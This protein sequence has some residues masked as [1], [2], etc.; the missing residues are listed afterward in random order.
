MRLAFWKKEDPK[1]RK[2]K[3]VAREWVD[4][5]IFAIVAATIIRTFLVEAYTIPTASMEGSMLTGDYLF[6][7]KVAYGPRIPNTPLA[8]P[9]VHNTMPI[10]GGKSY[11]EAV[12]WD[13][14]R[15]WGLGDV[16]RNDVV[17]FNF[18]AGDTVA[19]EVQQEIDYYSLVRAYGR[20]NVH[21]QYTIMTRPI[22]KKENYIKRCVG[23]PGDKLQV[24]NGTVYV[25]DKPGRL[26][27]HAQ[28]SYLIK[29]NGQPV[30][31]DFLDEN[32]IEQPIQMGP[33]IYRFNLPN[34]KIEPIKKQPNV[35][36]VEP[37]VSQGGVMPH[38][39]EEWVYPQDTNFKWSRDNYGP[40]TIPKKGATVQLTPQNIAL[41]RRIIANYEKHQLVENNGQILI[42]GQPTTSYT[43]G[44][45]YYWMM[46][47]NRHRSSDSRFWG[48]VP[49]D[50]IVGKASFVWFSRG[51]DGI[52][53][54]RLF[55]GVGAL[56]K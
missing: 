21:A 6:V 22:D 3:S 24:V 55:R 49:E 20:E 14:H 18:P 34:D 7:S 39:V 53:W 42:D 9:L 5:A 38:A 48:F 10:T 32:G 1:N 35:I 11:S 44:M 50:H 45:D 15:W 52:R 13:Y 17:V 40:I 47:D 30:S 43:F 37:F 26:F 29:T 31:F 54:S 19:M 46:G 8:V 33:G 36:A 16:E 56:S 25:N 28:M 51:D 41:Y 23:I 4:A 12:Q 2:K 27:P